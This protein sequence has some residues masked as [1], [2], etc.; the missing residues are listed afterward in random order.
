[1]SYFSYFPLTSVIMNEQDVKIVQARNIM[2]RAKF[3]DF[4][5]N[6]EGLFEKY[7]I[8]EGE[9]PDTL[10]YKFYGRSELHW[11]I[12]MFNEIVDPF[13]EW[14]LTTN[15]LNSLITYRYPGKAVYVDDS[16]FYS[17]GSKR[18]QKISDTEPIIDGSTQIQVIKNN[19][20][21]TLTAITYDPS[22][23][24]LVVLDN[25][26][27]LTLGVPA[28]T[29]ITVTNS[30]GNII[31]SSIR[32]IEENST[33]LHHFADNEGDILDPRGSIDPYRDAQGV[34][35]RALIYSDPVLRQNPIFLGAVNNTDYEYDKNEQKRKIDLLKPYYIDSVL[36]QFSTLMNKK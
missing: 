12:L 35:V 8:R 33:A 16:F 24:K 32:Y 11:I 7:Q 31:Q 17:Q 5:K 2:L 29:T 28:N 1:M 10:A 26:N 19:T 21:K 4:I 20:T 13:Y 6:R 18:N 3:S 9:R 15:E 34:V 14:P 30:K 36:K 22:L 23:L 25:D 27:F